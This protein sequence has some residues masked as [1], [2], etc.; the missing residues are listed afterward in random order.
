MYALSAKEFE[1]IKDSPAN[2]E[3]RPPIEYDGIN[4]P[5]C[6]PGKRHPLPAHYGLFRATN[7]VVYGIS[8]GSSEAVVDDVAKTVADTDTFGN[9]LHYDGGSSIWPVYGTPWR[10]IHV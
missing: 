8:A 7:S 10:S 3:A 1:C 9:T 6:I 5:H 4:C 2:W